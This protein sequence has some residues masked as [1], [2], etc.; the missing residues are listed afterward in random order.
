MKKGLVLMIL[1]ALIL[2]ACSGGGA[3]KDSDPSA[4]IEALESAW[5][6]KDADAAMVLFADDAVERN[7]LGTY[8]GK[9]AIR[10]VYQFVMDAH[11]TFMDCQNYQVNG[12]VV[13]YDC[14]YT[15]NDG[16]AVDG[17]RYEAVIEDGKIKSNMLVSNFEP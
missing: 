7:G 5:N 13:S 2:S 9:E 17:E 3:S 8:N 6:A 10:R 16:L 4:I 15:D 12:D 1:L 11:H 14:V